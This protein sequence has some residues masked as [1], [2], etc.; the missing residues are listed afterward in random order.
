MSPGS[1]NRKLD[2]IAADLTKPTGRK[3]GSDLLFAHLAEGLDSLGYV[4]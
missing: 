2:P 3:S 1:Q 4:S